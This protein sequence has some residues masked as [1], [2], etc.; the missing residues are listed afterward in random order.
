MSARV[1]WICYGQEKSATNTPIFLTY[2]AQ[3]LKACGVDLPQTTFQIDHGTEWI[4]PAPKTAPEP[5][6]FE[7]TVAAFG[8]TYQ[9]IPPGACT[10]QSDVEA[11]HRLIEDEFYDHEDY[12]SRRH[13]CQK[14]Y[15]YVTYFNTQRRFRYK[16]DQTPLEI[17]E[18]VAPE[19][20]DTDRIVVLPPILLDAAFKDFTFKG[21]YHVPRSVIFL[22]KSQ[23]TQFRANKISP[24]S[25]LKLTPA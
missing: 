4:G 20:V 1:T 19:T 17:L 8:A 7:Q 2:L 16:E 6:L 15:T 11:M 21:G 3:H 25:L 10:Y 9:T 24:A 22:T 14:A 13:L 5:T 23:G 18:R 12:Q